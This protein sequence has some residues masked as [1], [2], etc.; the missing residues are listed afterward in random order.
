MTMIDS[1]LKIKC[2]KI[3]LLERHL[4]RLYSKYHYN[5]EE[6][7]RSIKFAETYI[8]H[9]QAPYTG[10][11]K[12]EQWQKNLIFRPIFGLYKKDKD[13]NPTDQ[14]LIRESFFFIPRKNA[15]TTI[16]AVLLLYLTVTEGFRGQTETYIAAAKREQ[17]NICFNACAGFI[18]GSKFLTKIFGEPYYN[19]IE[20]IQTKSIIKPL[21]GNS[22]KGSGL[23]ASAALCDEIH[24]HPN[25]DLINIIRTSMAARKNPLLFSATTSGGNKF[26]PCWN[27]Y[28]YSDK[29]LN[30]IIDDDTFLPIVFEVD[31]GVDLDSVMAYEMANPNIDVSVQRDY[32]ERE[33][34]K[35]RDQKSYAPTYHRM[36]LNRWTSIKE[37][38]WFS[39]NQLD[40]I[41]KDYDIYDYKDL[42]AFAGIDLA[43]KNDLCAL[44]VIIPKDGKFYSKLWYW[45][46]ES[47]VH[48]LE[49]EHKTPYQQWI[50]EGF[51]EVCPGDTIDSRYLSERIIDILSPF[52]IKHLC[53][54]PA[55][56]YDIS[57]VLIDE[58]IKVSEFRQSLQNYT[59][60]CLELEN[61]VNNK[62][63]L[64]DNNKITYWCFTNGKLFINFKG[65]RKPHKEYKNTAEK[66]DGLCACLFAIEAEYRYRLENNE[67]GNN[68][69]EMDMDDINTFKKMFLGI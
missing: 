22:T 65:Q 44:S 3:K 27:L 36:H 15:K 4:E 47:K 16:S 53:F 17:A 67:T 61:K 50:D 48:E 56:A 1:G 68:Y 39:A 57:P 59:Y 54:D 64:I 35:A 9:F 34:K 31:E 51:L 25:T 21:S 58:G 60:S 18:R 55:F 24:E 13:G 26:G 30:G 32:I 14:R 2:K 41:Q 7:E 10:K 63:F 29:I 6:A 11:L 37:E 40:E 46:P 66:N 19:R 23:S 38:R 42:D 62:T 45:L 20:M 43:Q 33:R 12:L 69:E 49:Q 8:N 5:E 52:K 28:D